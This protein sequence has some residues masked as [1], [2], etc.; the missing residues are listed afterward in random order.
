MRRRGANR[1]APIYGARMTSKLHAGAADVFIVA[2]VLAVES[3]LWWFHGHP[4]PS[5]A[6]ASAATT[7]AAITLIAV[8][9]AASTA[10]G[11]ATGW[12]AYAALAVILVIVGEYAA[13]ASDPMINAHGRRPV[14]LVA[15]V[16]VALIAWSLGAFVARR[17]RCDAARATERAANAAAQAAIARAT[18]AAAK[19]KAVAAESTRVARERYAAIDAGFQA[20]IVEVVA[21]QQ[22]LVRG[23]YPDDILSRMRSAEDAIHQTLVALE[24]HL[25]APPPDSGSDASPA[26]AAGAAGPDGVI[27]ADGARQKNRGSVTKRGKAGAGAAAVP[28]NRSESD[29]T[30]TPSNGDGLPAELVRR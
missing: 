27:G 22:A 25:T 17:A 4:A 14:A 11:T 15:G 10:A 28:A 12:R 19:A 1:V 23:A 20:A 26:G 30:A 6:A 16:V 8:V 18:Q 2:L 21:S 7:A 9:L 29:P 13:V 3:Q 5:G 24:R